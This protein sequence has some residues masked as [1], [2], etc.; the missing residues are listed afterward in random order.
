MPYDCARMPDERPF[1]ASTSVG[2]PRRLLVVVAVLAVLVFTG[3]AV[4]ATRQHVPLLD[5]SIKALD[6]KQREPWLTPAMRWLSRLG[7]GELLLP[8]TAIVFVLLRRIRHPLAPFVPAIT[9]GTCA[10]NLLTKW[11]VGRPRPTMAPYGFP[12]GH[13]LASVVFFGGIVYIVWG[14][15]IPRLARW[16]ATAGCALAVLGVAYSRVYLNAHW[17][18]DVLGGFAGGT[19]YLSLALALVDSRRRFRADADA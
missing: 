18:T 17:L 9:L 14:L 16:A 13:V 15:S 4:T 5:L 6:L 7:S 12:S 2:V 3:L 10:V 11:A 1:D 19:A 8:L